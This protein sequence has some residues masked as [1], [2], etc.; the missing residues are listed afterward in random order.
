MWTTPE[1]AIRY[2]WRQPRQANSLKPWSE[3][4][5]HTRHVGELA[6]HQARRWLQQASHFDWSFSSNK[7]WCMKNK[8]RV[9]DRRGGDITDTWFIMV[10]AVEKGGSRVATSMIFVP[11]QGHEAGK[12]MAIP[13][14]HTRSLG[15]C[16][17]LR[18]A[19]H[20]VHLSLRLGMPYFRPRELF[21]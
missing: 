13:D 4:R 5:G 10:H 20:R 21:K 12:T 15:N 17:A 16:E 8:T 2:F 19:F 18:S 11:V 9:P 14:G 1:L 6:M 7:T 3:R